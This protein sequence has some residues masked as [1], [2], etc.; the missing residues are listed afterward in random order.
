MRRLKRTLLP[1]TVEKRLLRLDLRAGDVCVD[2][3]ANVGAVSELLLDRGCV[4]HAYEP[5]PQAFAALHAR[6]GA[7]AAFFGYPQAV[8]NTRERRKLFLHSRH[9]EDELAFSQGAS[10]RSDKRNVGEDYVSVDVVAIGDVL[11]NLPPIKV[12]KI[13]VE[14]EEYNILQDIVDCR[15]HDRIHYLLCESHH[16]KI[17]DLRPL[18]LQ[19]RDTISQM[20]LA[21]RW[22]LDWI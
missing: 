6:L 8:S 14:G 11:G 15:L 17:A 9:G 21:E 7:H 18:Y 13:D 12:L 10:L 5:H 3:G 19:Y 1:N 2:I 22:T 20:G 16:E 4:V